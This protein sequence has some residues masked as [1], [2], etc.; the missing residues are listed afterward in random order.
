MST[1]FKDFYECEAKAD[2]IGIGWPRIDGQDLVGQL[3]MIKTVVSRVSGSR[4]RSRE[5]GTSVPAS[6]STS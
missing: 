6:K 5:S 3:A 2:G 4:A 1:A